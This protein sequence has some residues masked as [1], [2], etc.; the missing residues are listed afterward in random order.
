[1]IVQV[2]ETRERKAYNN[3]YPTSQV[4]QIAF[5]NFEKNNM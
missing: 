5:L 4:D 3:N 2:L 1:M